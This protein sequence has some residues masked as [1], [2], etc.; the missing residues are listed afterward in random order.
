MT[1]PQP[2]VINFVDN[3]H[4]PEFFA[5]QLAGGAYDGPN[6]VRLTFS[7]ARVNQ[8]EAARLSGR[9]ERGGT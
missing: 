9:N 5:S 2:L 8:A 4:A 7:S 1:D 3:P 6:I